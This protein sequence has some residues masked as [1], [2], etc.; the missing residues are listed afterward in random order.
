MNC[1]QVGYSDDF[2]RQREADERERERQ[3]EEQRRENQRARDEYLAGL[4]AKRAE[5]RKR[6]EQALD[7]ELEP[8]KQ[9]MKRDWLVAHPDKTETDFERQAWP[10][11]RQNAI[12]DQRE[13]QIQATMAEMRR[14]GRY[15]L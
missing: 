6:A 9:R 15:S 5:E 3:L 4:E 10:L 12:E 11:L 1:R 2:R 7:R 14:S 8:H 13:Q